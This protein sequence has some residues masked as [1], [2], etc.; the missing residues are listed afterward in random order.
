MKKYFLYGLLASTFFLSNS[1]ANTF[2]C[3]ATA[4]KM[5]SIFSEK[6]PPIF[7]KECNDAM[8][9]HIKQG[10]TEWIINSNV[11]SNTLDNNLLDDIST[12]VT[13]AIPKNPNAVLALFYKSYHDNIDSDLCAEP[14]EN[15]F[16]LQRQTFD[17]SA[18]T[19][20]RVAKIPA[21]LES[22]R[23]QCIASFIVDKTC[24]TTAQAMKSAFTQQTIPDFS[25]VCIDSMLNHIE[26][27]EN[28]W[29][30]NYQVLQN[31]GNAALSESL[32]I[33]LT[34]AIPNNPVA[35]LELYYQ[36][37]AQASVFCYAPFI[38]GTTTQIITF[39]NRAINALKTATVPVHLEKLRQQCI[40]SFI[41]DK[42][43]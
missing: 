11:M 33:T 34:L 42:E 9:N 39:D 2:A 25:S 3:P 8:L 26:Q 38:E 19:A 30:A 18:I 6:N 27:G 32:P 31:T 5:K 40:V 13:L 35:I 28:D 36:T 20:L 43:T 21:H 15:S 10:D 37:S 7:S 22:L 17:E 12:A 4:E 14:L 24:P 16:P 1:M 41:S 29:I 23:Q